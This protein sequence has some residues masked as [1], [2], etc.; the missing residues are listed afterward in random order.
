MARAGHQFPGFVLPLSG[1]H[2]GIVLVFALTVSFVPVIHAADNPGE[3][4]RRQFEAAKA[5]LG[6]GNLDQAESDYRQTI[7]LGL[8][9]LGNLSISEEQFEQATRLLDEAVKHSRRRRP[10]G[11]S[12]YRLVSQGDPRRLQNW[13]GRSSH[14]SGQR[15]RTMFSAV[16]SFSRA[17]PE[18]RSKS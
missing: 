15:A 10:T 6:S 18:D 3:A 14:E 1:R 7:A 9:R 16:S 11:G 13:S 5:S 4:L 8:R 12:G 17:I 2:R